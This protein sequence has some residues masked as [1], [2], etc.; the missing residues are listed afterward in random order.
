MKV[1]TARKRRNRATS[2]SV[3]ATGPGSLTN[4]LSSGTICATSA[5]LDSWTRRV[6]SS[7][8]RT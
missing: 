6:A 4:A 7:T 2:G 8:S 5:A 1:V 3:A